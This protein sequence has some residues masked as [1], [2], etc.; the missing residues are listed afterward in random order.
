[1][2]SAIQLNTTYEQEDAQIGLVYYSKSF[3]SKQLI[4]GMDYK[5][6]VKNC[7]VQSEFQILVLKRIMQISS[8]QLC[9]FVERDHLRT[10]LHQ[11]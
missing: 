6:V 9:E 8:Y 3:T 5:F 10:T 11:F 4:T 2:A 1:M 7:R